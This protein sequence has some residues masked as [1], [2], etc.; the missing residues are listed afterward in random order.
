MSS[1]VETFRTHTEDPMSQ[2]VLW[3]GPN[4]SWYECLGTAKRAGERANSRHYLQSDVGLGPVLQVAQQQ[5]R[6]SVH[7]V[8]ADQLLAA[9]PTEAWQTL[10]ERPSCPLHAWGLV[11]AVSQ[12][13][14]GARGGRYFTQLTTGDRQTRSELKSPITVTV[15]INKGALSRPPDVPVAPG[16]GAGVA[17]DLVHTLGAVLALVLL[18]VI[19]VHAAVVAHVSR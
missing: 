18:T 3:A 9:R 6:V 5:V 13:A 11:L 16:A 14:E 19:V 4:T 10:A 15:V 12:V 17:V 7:E 8:D 2:D 1:A